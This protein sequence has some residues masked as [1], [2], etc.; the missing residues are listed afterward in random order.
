[1]RL[2]NQG[3]SVLGSPEDIRRFSVAL[4][5]DYISDLEW[6]VIP[7]C[8]YLGMSLKKITQWFPD[9]HLGLKTRVQ[10]HLEFIGPAV[11][12]QPI[13]TV[14]T[15]QGGTRE[16]SRGVC[17]LRTGS[18]ILTHLLTMGTPVAG[19]QCLVVL[20][21]VYKCTDEAVRSRKRMNTHS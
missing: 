13:E 4:H 15:L 9:Y 8:R 6:V 18:Y 16:G 11:D 5:G 1:M 20:A 17:D 12:A 21:I 10:I 19:G 14:D 2:H 3:P 7:E